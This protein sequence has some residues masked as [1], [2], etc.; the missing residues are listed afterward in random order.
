MNAAFFVALLCLPPMTAHQREACAP[1]L[2]VPNVDPS[3]L[4]YCLAN[5]KKAED[6]AA[7]LQAMNAANADLL[8]LR[9]PC[10]E[11]GISFREED[12]SLRSPCRQLLFALKTKTAESLYGLEV[13]DAD[14]QN[15]TKSFKACVASRMQERAD[16]AEADRLQAIRAEQE[17]KFALA[18][19]AAK[20]NPEVIQTVS[21]ARLCDARNERR[22]VMEKIANEH[23]Y[24]RRV[25]V[26]NLRELEDLKDDLRAVD[27]RIESET[28]A[29]NDVRRSPLRCNDPKINEIR[30][31]VEG[32]SS[33][34]C[35][36]E[37]VRI[38]TT[39]FQG[40]D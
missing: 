10:T 11:S 32:E 9:C 22:D 4:G 33:E 24:A 2:S 6:Q 35:S 18:V 40:N 29:L 37:R 38:R 7:R 15:A 12:V 19:A 8:R 34:R 36:S 21:S 39:I 5:A 27:D 25:G 26:I 30:A 16:R 17:S 1:Y 3:A 23:K 31:C 28:A 20:E 13:P 14:I